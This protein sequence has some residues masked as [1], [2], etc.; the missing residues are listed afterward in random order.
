MRDRARAEGLLNG[1]EDYLCR[2]GC[3]PAVPSSLRPRLPALHPHRW[4]RTWHSGALPPPNLTPVGGSLARSGAGPRRRTGAWRV[5]Q[6]ATST[7]YDATGSLVTDIYGPAR[8]EPL[9]RSQWAVRTRLRGRRG[10]VCRH[11]QLGWG[12]DPLSPPFLLNVSAHS[13][14]SS[15]AAIASRS[16]EVSSAPSCT[17]PTAPAACAAS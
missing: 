12:D 14:Q 11:G 6:L 17:S 15:W 2:S 7:V 3:R 8:T 1:C 10:L 9:S 5:G 4:R 16:R 13:R